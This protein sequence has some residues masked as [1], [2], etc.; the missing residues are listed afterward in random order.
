MEPPPSEHSRCEQSPAQ[1]RRGLSWGGRKDSQN[2]GDKSQ[3]P[4]A[5][6]LGLTTTWHYCFS[7]RYHHHMALSAPTHGASLHKAMTLHPFFCYCFILST[8]QGLDSGGWSLQ[9]VPGQELC[10]KVRQRSA[11][12]D[13]PELSSLLPYYQPQSIFP[14]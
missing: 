9:G 12:S 5:S 11:L 7:P 3:G 2:R 4:L 10:G 6:V 13:S 8:G 1:G 14:L